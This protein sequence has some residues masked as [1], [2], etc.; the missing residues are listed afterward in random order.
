MEQKTYIDEYGITCIVLEPST[1]K[2]LK[3]INK[4]LKWRDDRIKELELKSKISKI[5]RDC[6]LLILLKFYNLI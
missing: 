2:V 6:Y 1:M 5:K 4:K 3:K